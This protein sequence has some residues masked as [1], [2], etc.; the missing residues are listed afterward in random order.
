MTEPLPDES[1]LS[2]IAP[3]RTPQQARSKER[4]DRILDAAAELLAA[5]GYN[6]VKT[7]HIAK[8]AGVSIGSVY[9][10][11]PNRFAIFHALAE[12][13][14]GRI[15]EVLAQY[16]G[17]D[18]T[19]LAWDDALDKTI[20]ALADLWRTEWT[21]FAV[22]IAIQN[23]AEL[24]EPDDDYKNRVLGEYALPFYRRM[25]PKTPDDRLV[26]IAGVVFDVFSLLLDSSMRSGGEQD[27]DL[28]DELRL[29]VKG[30]LRQHI[31]LEQNLVQT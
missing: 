14:R 26:K 24:R 22:W 8:R 12:R 25:L 5:E 13:Y 23:T 4:V 15:S 27:Q 28:V 21:F 6:A 11:F 18:A 1:S 10:F 31:A 2:E 16:I 9:Q 3:R 29:V 20:E 30:Y 17:P 7:N 19:H